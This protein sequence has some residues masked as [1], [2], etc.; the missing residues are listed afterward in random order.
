MNRFT[1]YNRLDLD[2]NE[3]S[4]DIDIIKKKY[5]IKALIYHP[6]KN[7][8][9]DA[10]SKF[11]EIHDAYE[12]VMKEEGYMDTEDNNMEN[13]RN[14]NDQDDSYRNLFLIFLKKILE[15]ETGDSIF[16]SIIQRIT[17]I[18]ES[19][20]IDLLER[21]DKTMLIK[22]RMILSKYKD[23]FHVTDTMLEKINE[24]IQ[25]RNENDEC[26]I[27]NP[28]WTDLCENNLYKLTVNNE[29]YI[30]PLWHHELVYENNGH[31]IYVNCLPDLP[32]YIT[33]DE[34][35]HIH[36][37]VKYNVAEIWNTE[38]IHV[39]CDARTF[40]IHVPSLKL[41]NIQTIIFVKQGISKMNTTNIYDIS[42]KSDV[43]VTIHLVI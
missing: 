5:R 26:I 42:T 4:I 31:D 34:Y 29:T 18:C 22:T 35:N 2:L 36:V 41:T 38:Y 1:A 15:N 27:L 33:I 11:Q 39:N 14:H 6:D 9:P 12:Y 8:N 25:S 13:T 23:A 28:T 30:I 40:P 3:D 37:D 17:T 19:K 20:A 32:S 24:L 7:N 10:S 16:Y 43:H 21:L